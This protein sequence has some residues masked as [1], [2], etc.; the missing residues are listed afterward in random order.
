MT[1]L[2]EGSVGVLGHESRG[3]LLAD[4]GVVGEPFDGAAYGSGVAEGVPR[5]EQV[6]VFLV[7]FVLEPL[8]ETLDVLDSEA[9]LAD[10]RE[11]LAELATADAPVLS[12]DQ[13]LRLIQRR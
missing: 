8:E 10:I 4:E 3:G 12:K 6:R 9:L 2:R 11:A 5:W 13:A 1:S 7:Q